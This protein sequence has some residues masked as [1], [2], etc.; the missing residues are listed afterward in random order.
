MGSRNGPGP[1]FS[2][3]WRTFGPRPQG[4]CDTVP[5]IFASTKIG[6]FRP[7]RAAGYYLTLQIS[8]KSIPV[9]TLFPRNVGSFSRTNCFMQLGLHVRIFLKRAGTTKIDKK[10]TGDEEYRLF[11]E[12]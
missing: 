11:P 4:G 12:R 2:L 1:G 9:K 6:I 7:E 3:C 10:P 5:P 8:I